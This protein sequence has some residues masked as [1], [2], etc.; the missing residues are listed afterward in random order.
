MLRFISMA[1]LLFALFFLITPLSYAGVYDTLEFGDTRGEVTKKLQASS[2]V[3]QQLDSAFFGR[4]GL[5][6]VFKCKAKLAGLTYRLYFDWTEAGGLREVTLRSDS[7]SKHNFNS[8]LKESWTQANKLFTQ[9]YG[10]P[11]Q[12][13]KYPQQSDFKGHDILMTH[14]WHKGSSQSMLIGP[15]LDKGK[16]FLAIRFVN[17]RIKPI[18]TP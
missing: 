8:G 12:G 4:T 3:E 11:V 7:I 9:V 6:G 10:N 5:N 15:G 17:K 14:I 16:C 2:M 13:A 1:R 18:R